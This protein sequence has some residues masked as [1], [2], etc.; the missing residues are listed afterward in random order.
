MPSITFIYR[1]GENRQLFYGKYVTDYISDDH[2]GLDLE[3]KP[4][5]ITSI[6]KKRTQEGLEELS[7]EEF[8]IGVISLFTDRFIASYSSQ[9]EIKAFD[10]YCNYFNYSKQVYIN[11]MLV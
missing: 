8:Q 5:L 3:V 11:G 9:E 4:T 2:E 1:I 7:E 10:F 6:N